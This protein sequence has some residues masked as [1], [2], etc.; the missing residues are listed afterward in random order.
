[1]EVSRNQFPFKLVEIIEHI[2]NSHFVAIDLELSGI[3]TRQTGSNRGAKPSLQ[4][5]YSDAKEAAER[6]TVL[7]VGLTVVEEDHENSV[8]LPTSIT[9]PSCLNQSILSAHS[10]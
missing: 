3:P 1:M 8:Y 7:Q 6:Y 5:V 2:A 9:Q 4:G 10:M